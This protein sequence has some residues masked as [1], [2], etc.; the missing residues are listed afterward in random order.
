[1]T[2]HT[3]TFC[4]ICEPLCGM[5]ATVEDGKLVA[6]RPDKDHPVSQGFACPKGIAFADLHN[7][8]DRVTTPL[9]KRADGGFEPVSW[10]EAM[11][12]IAARLRDIHRRHGSGALG[13]YFGN[14]G[15]FSYSHQLWL[16]V[17]LLG[18]GLRSHLF[19]AGSQD[20]N[21]RFV[22]SQLL[23]GSP[24]ALPVPDVLRTDFLVVI[25]ANPIVSHGS[26]VTAPRI[27]DRMH[28]IVKRGGRVLVID[29]R[30]TETAAQFEWLGIV[31]DGDAYLLLSLLQVM[32][33]ENLADRVAIDARADGLDWLERLA[34]P[35]T[36]E[37]TQRYTGIGPETVRGLARDLVATPRAAV[38]GRLGTSVGRSGTLTTYL[39][40]A[41]NLLAGNLDRPGGAMFGTF[42]IP[43]ERL[44]MKGAAGALR[45][46]YHRKRSRIGD[47]PSVLLSEPAGIMA[48]EI[49]TPG[50]GQ[51]RALFVS[52]GNPVL[53]VPNGEELQQAMAGLEL[54]V[55][56]D[57]YVNETTAHCDYV[58]PATTMYERDD[59]PLPF[60]L[61]QPTPFRQAT[62]AVVAPAGQAREEWAII[63]ELSRRLADRTPALRALQI[64]RKALGFFG[65]R[66]TPRL[67]ADAVIR[68]GAGGD[69][70]GLNRGGLTFRRLTQQHPH[71]VVLAPNLKAG[72]L[73]TVVV[74]RGAKVR[75]VHAEIAA[76]IAALGR[77]TDPDGYPL[78][79]IGM[80]ELRSE[81]SWMHNVPLLMRGDRTQTALMHVDDAA[82]LK[83]SDGDRV[84]VS[85]PHGEIE[86]PVVLT[87]DIVAGVIAIPHGWGHS[88]A[89]G[90]RTAN[91]AGGANVNQ[92]MSS[93]PEDLEKLAGMARLTG[94]AVVVEPV[95]S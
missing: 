46:V 64:I 10:D 27:R 81:N 17:L 29:P 2:Q 55:G 83:L 68:L 14:P 76:E 52:A 72:V 87:K 45:F 22:A 8:P 94:V 6:L 31:P 39:L 13:W 69:R 49:A 62:E 11:T 58:L 74:Y 36:P 82:D 34:A 7:D 47:F 86:I 92:L 26:A 16:N 80:R 32:L 85:S 71:G 91:G 79:L 61:L 77:R 60:Q 4:R 9:R 12:D 30:K 70:F 23:Y 95:G 66:L 48:K 21:N 25:G 15:A 33:A 63:D 53:S 78:R 67:V 5:I 44:M 84:R 93:A 57:L 54:A 1:M 50:P 51:V 88:G 42:G 19:T 65:L 37:A 90:W 20:I 75:L 24:L 38:Y 59:F 89:G 41:V 40:D 3:P 35:F 73:P 18:M 43:A 56:I 28:E